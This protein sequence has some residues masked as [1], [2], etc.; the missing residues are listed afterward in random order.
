[1]AASGGDS[2]AAHADLAAL[3]ADLAAQ[4][5]SRAMIMLPHDAALAAIVHLTQHGRRLENW[6]GWVRL[7]DGSRAKSLTHSGSFA[8]SRDAA[9]AAETA[10]AAI[11]KAKAA[12]DRN[13]EFPGAELYFGLTFGP[14]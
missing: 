10:S 6:E 13:P 14:T 3:P 12:W 4:S 1:M 7:R 2:F 8:L 5:I 11:R 9:R